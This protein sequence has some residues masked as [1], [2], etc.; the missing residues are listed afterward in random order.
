MLLVSERR[1][2]AKTQ[3]EVAIIEQGLWDTAGNARGGGRCQHRWAKG[4]SQTL[5]SRRPCHPV[6][7]PGDS[8]G[9]SGES[10]SFLGIKQ[11][12]RG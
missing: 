3:K 10:Q 8:H 6:S 4:V 5:C 11:E 2:T 12:F 7:P 9:H 1:R